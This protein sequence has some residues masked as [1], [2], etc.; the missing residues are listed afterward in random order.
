MRRKSG[1]KIDRGFAPVGGGDCAIK[2]VLELRFGATILEGCDSALQIFF[3]FFGFESR[4]RG[5]QIRLG[6]T[7]VLERFEVFALEAVINITGQ[8]LNRVELRRRRVGRIRVGDGDCALSCC[9]ELSR[10]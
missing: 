5:D 2:R 10:R 8:L 6:H 9:R 4:H 7:S 1:N 3:F